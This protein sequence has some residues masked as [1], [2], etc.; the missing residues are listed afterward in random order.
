MPIGTVAVLLPQIIQS[1]FVWQG[2]EVGG[3]QGP[4][5]GLTHGGDSGVGMAAWRIKI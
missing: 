2:L 5:Q 1:Y 4:M 3:I